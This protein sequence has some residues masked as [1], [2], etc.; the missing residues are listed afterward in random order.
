MRDIMKLTKDT[1]AAL[2]RPTNKA[3]HIEWCN[4]M[5]GFGV[6]LRGDTKR[7]VVQYRVGHQ[8]RRES[9]GD[10][11]KVELE[12]ARKAARKRFAQIELG[13]DPA[14]E[15]AKARAEH[16]AGKLTLKVVADRYLADKH[17]VMRPST[18]TAAKRYFERYWKPM[19]DQPLDA[20]KRADVAA[21][22]QEIVKGSGRTTAA[23]ARS[24]LSALFGW[25]MR[26][27][28][29][30]GNPVI[31]TNDPEAGIK[32]RERVLDDRELRAIWNACRDDD[33]GRI[34][35][36]LIL[37]GC[38]R[39]A[40]HWRDGYSWGAHKKSS[41]PGTH[42]AAIGARY[43]AAAATWPGQRFRH[44]ETV[45]RVVVSDDGAQEPDCRR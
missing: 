42:A 23:R 31:G 16:A 10:V 39:E 2:V 22:L 33:F 34:I 20:I 14:A 27:G 9:L 24:N 8:Q 29:C 1:V 3:D 26:E 12:D 25:A 6:R 38:R 35:K 30:E 43:V 15:R 45:Q 37:T 5:P 40:R 32:P 19:H 17:D 11:R 21:R 18:Y 44:D 41:H 4:D 13:I 7:W 36:L 28:L